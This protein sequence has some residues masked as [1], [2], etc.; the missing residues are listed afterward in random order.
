M[1]NH[2]NLPFERGST[3][4]DGDSTRATSVGVEHILGQRFTVKNDG[5]NERRRVYYTGS[6]AGATAS[7]SNSSDEVELVVVRND[8]GSSI[9]AGHGVR[10]ATGSAGAMRLV[11]GSVAGVGNFGYP[12]D[13]MYGTSSLINN[14]LFYVV[15]KGPCLVKCTTNGTKADLIE[16]H[17]GVQF[18]GR[19]EI[20]LAA[21]DQYSIG[22][23]LTAGNE[24]TTGQQIMIYVQPGFQDLGQA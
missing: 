3:Y 9:T 23:A 1:S 12:T 10:F 4:F 6:I 13:D 2:A 5:W 15:T 14:D 18:N 17:A 19:G 20:E 24:T 8:S 22:Y 11:A 21:A 16:P 7:V